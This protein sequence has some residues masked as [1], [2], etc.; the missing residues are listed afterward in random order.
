M[1]KKYP[2]MLLAAA[3]AFVWTLA[4]FQGQRYEQ[5]RSSE[6]FFHW[7]IGAANQYR[8]GAALG[9]SDAP[10][11]VRRY[12]RDFFDRVNAQLED[13][14]PEIPLAPEDMTASV[15]HPKLVR[16]VRDA[17]GPDG[18]FTDTTDLMLVWAH[19]NSESFAPL[20][21][22]F[23]DSL[24][25]NM[26][27]H[28]SSHVAYADYSQA[29]GNLANL[30]F[31][32][33]KVAANF[34]WLQV[35]RYWHQGLT[36]RMYPLMLT[37]VALDPHF[38]DAFLLGAWHL[39]YNA[40]AHMADTPEELKECHPRYGVRLGPKELYYYRAIDLLQDGIRKNPWNYKL[41]FDLGYSIY[42]RK[43]SDH[44]NAVKYLSEAIRYRHDRWVPRMLYRSMQLNGQ[45]EDAIAGWEDYLERFPDHDVAQRGLALNRALLAESRAEEA[46]E[47]SQELE[48]QVAVLQRVVSELRDRIEQGASEE[49]QD[50]ALIGELAARQQELA[51]LRRETLQQIAE[52]EARF[53]EAVR[54]YTLLAGPDDEDTFAAARLLWMRAR[55]Y[56]QNARYLEAISLLDN[57]RW[58]SNDIWMEA[59]DEIIRVKKLADIE[60][61]Y[62]ERL[63]VE[64]QRE[65]EAFLATV[66]DCP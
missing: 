62:S 11:E 34:I 23:T 12:E 5:L 53:A 25:R 10:E 13:A 61:A 3:L 60:L 36:A 48:E 44:E 20:R 40:T 18:S 52:A 30:F 7:M 19:F 42:E 24:S 51:Q 33:R 2:N 16:I 35:D 57:A 22:E 31:G 29:G 45:H 54:G 6:I 59:T 28:A 4:A 26:L 47:A 9:D 50:P 15:V 65:T 14:L 43:M 49:A 1:S 27:S 38:V 17:V 66:P 55:G 39:A 46:L 64:R 8:I 21:E 32:F 56:V 58:L 37:C 41:Y 63:Y